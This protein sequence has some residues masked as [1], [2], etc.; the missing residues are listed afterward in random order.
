MKLTAE[1]PRIVGREIRGVVR[2]VLGGD[3]EP[4]SVDA[5]AVH[6]GG[7]S[8][9]DRVQGG[10]DLADD[11]MDVS[12]S[13]LREYGNMSS[14][15]VLFILQRILADDSL[16]DGAVGRRPVLRPRAH[17]GGRALHAAARPGRPS[18]RLA[19]RRC[20]PRRARRR[21]RRA[22][23]RPA[24]A[25]PCGWPAR[26]GGSALI[27]R[28]LAGWGT[29]YRAHVRP[30]LRAGGRPRSAAR[31][32]MRRRRRAAPAGGQR[33]RRRL[34]GRGRRHRPGRARA[35][36]RPRDAGRRHPVSRPR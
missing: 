15:T 11:A 10:L 8:V 12:R 16:A 4:S 19:R 35:G 9:L 7:R 6:P 33:T 13:V 29:V 14:A 17:G 21:A 5:W 34:H 27:N 25:I 1:V 36:R 32:R 28:L 20:D 24:R 3:A 26:C 2:T 18:P 30:A 22:H 23:G 31:H